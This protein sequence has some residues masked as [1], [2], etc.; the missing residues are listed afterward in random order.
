[1]INIIN[2]IKLKLKSNLIWILILSSTVAT[3]KYF[4]SKK[5]P[6]LYLSYS[7]IFPLTNGENN[8]PLAGI[9]SQFGIGA[10]SDL[11]TYYNVQELVSSKNLSRRIV[12]YPSNNIK[13]P[14]LFNWIINDQNKFKKFYEKK[15]TLSKDSI[16][17]IIFASE[18]LSNII[19][20]KKEKTEFT[21]ISC[22]TADEMLSLRLNEVVLQCLSDYYF[23]SKTEK[24]RT[25]LIRIGQLRDS[26]KNSLDIIEKAQAGNN[27]NLRFIQDESA[28]LPQIKL[29]RLHDEVE[30]QYKTTAMAFQNANFKLLY[31]SPIF[32]VLDKPIGPLYFT[33]ASSSKAAMIAFIISFILFCIIAI[34]KVIWQLV[35]SE[36][37]NEN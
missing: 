19:T 32:Q 14:Q 18:L 28:M 20:I 31:E 25:D 29:A 11:S 26:L 30:E 9:K 17:N 15:S 4:L 12:Q 37:A 13:E 5:E 16:E 21:S 23:Q 22:T 1:M 36:L 24:A 35:L 6:R 34:R 10:S 8:D 33:K 3:I 7:K 2:E 27:D